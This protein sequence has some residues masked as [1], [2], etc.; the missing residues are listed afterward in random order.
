MTRRSAPPDPYRPSSTSQ[1]Q[2][3]I[4]P[5]SWRVLLQ[6][7]RAHD[8]LRRVASDAHPHASLRLVPTSRLIHVG[9]FLSTMA[10]SDEA[11]QERRLYDLGQ[12]DAPPAS[13][14][15]AAN[16]ILRRRGRAAHLA[17]LTC[18]PP[19]PRRPST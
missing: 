11:L 5:T 12:K 19:P 18:A 17:T 6:R 15:R 8:V 14:V 4:A 2:P 3:Y 1:K 9:L 10:A 7:R 16:E 13:R